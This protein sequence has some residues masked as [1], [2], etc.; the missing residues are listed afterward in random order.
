MV[1]LR[2][3]LL[4]LVVLVAGLSLWMRDEILRLRS[5]ISLFDEGRI[6]ENFSHM[7]EIFHSVPIPVRGTVT[8]L[9]DGAQM[10]L[11]DDWEAWLDRRKVT[12][13]V[14][15]DEGRVVHESYHRGTGPADQRISWSMAKSYV[16]ALVGISLERGEIASLDDP[17]VTYV[18]ALA[19]GAYDGATVRDVLTMSSG[20]EFDEDYMDFWSDINQM[21]RVLALGR[22]MDAFAAALDRT[23]A[24]PGVEWHYVSIDT[25]VL[26]MVLRGA[27][28]RTLPDLLG[29]R[30]LTPL[31]AHGS[32]HYLA[33]GYGVAFALGGLNLTVR[34]YARLGEMFRNDG[35]FDGRQI[36]PAD[37]VATSTA[38][39][40]KTRPGA[41]QYGYQWWIAE[42]APEG[43]FMA[44][45][46]YGQYIYVNRQAGIVVAMTAADRGFRD[47]EAEPDAIAM[48]R[49]IATRLED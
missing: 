9:P 32:P 22:S 33:D 28:G 19:G 11:P 34:D 37:W 45:G 36:V 2:R 49:R 46:I 16:S 41:W 1:W 4:L 29:E 30:L 7:G 20:V 12:G 14:V 18:P 26:A 13:I 35:Y 10:R 40:A 31:G 43:E 5:T 27:T 25:H 17:V 39:R 47:P 24:E 6:V 15:L 44:R 3:F 21:G 42:D 48:L 38:P 23:Y 8:P